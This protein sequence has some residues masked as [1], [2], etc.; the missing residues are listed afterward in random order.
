MAAR[1]SHP[2][3]CDFRAVWGGLDI[4]MLFV[5]GRIERENDTADGWA[6]HACA[7]KF[8]WRCQLTGD[9]WHCESFHR[10]KWGVRST[11]RPIHAR[12]KVQEFREL[13]YTFSFAPCREHVMREMIYV[14]LRPLVRFQVRLHV[15]PLRLNGVGVIPLFIDESNGVINL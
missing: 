10:E 11:R 12:D 13:V 6:Q 4:S 15:I 7:V 9:H 14:V 2:W 3:Q 5:L 1:R 8:M